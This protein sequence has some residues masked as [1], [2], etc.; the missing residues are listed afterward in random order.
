MPNRAQ[1]GNDLRAPHTVL[2]RLLAAVAVVLAPACRSEPSPTVQAPPNPTS[3]PAT[4]LSACA[5]SHGA[6][7]SPSH[8]AA[9]G[10]DYAIVQPG[11][12]LASSVTSDPPFESLQS[13][14]PVGFDVDVIAEIARRLGLRP[15]IQSTTAANVLTDVAQGKA[16]VAISA[17]S[18][19]PEATSVVDFTTPYYIA[20]L[21]VAVAVDHARAFAGLPSL[22][23]VTVAVTPGTSAQTCAQAILASHPGLFAV[24]PYDDIS[25]AYTDLS[26]GRVGAV[27]ADVATADRLVQ[28]VPGLQMVQIYRTGDDYA[29]AVAKSNPSLRQAINRVLGDMRSD[30]TYDLLF[31]KWFQVPPP[32]S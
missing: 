14:Q 9:S 6:S 12:L 4:T 18:I 17:L 22:A 26:V 31:K 24:Q 21:A 10:G 27:L 11:L 3:A 8:G 2:V 15:E 30:G 16:D 13:G 7:R 32:G 28:A 5:I 25:K 29:I 1:K 23:G 19:R 20:D